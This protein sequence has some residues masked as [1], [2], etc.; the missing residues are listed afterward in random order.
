MKTNWLAP[1]AALALAVGSVAAA[2]RVPG[3]VDL[4]VRGEPRTPEG[5]TA[6]VKRGR[7]CGNEARGKVVSAALLSDE[8]L[9]EILPLERFG[10]VSYVVDSAG[11]TPVSGRF[12]KSI[13]RV[14]GAAEDVLLRRPDTV[15]VSDYTSGAAEAQL[16]AAG[17]CV[18]R[19]R[20][21]Q[22]FDDLFA[23][24]L[25]L[26]EATAS[27]A[28]ATALVERER[29]RLAELAS[30]PSQ[31]RRARVLLVQDPYSYGPGTLQADC[32]RLIGL[33]NVL[34]TNAFGKTP[35]LNVEQLLSLVPDFV[36]FASDTD[37]PRPLRPERRP[38]G[39]GWSRMR[40]LAEGRAFEVPSP[41]MA[42]I[43]HH[44]VDACE[45]YAR[46]VRG[47]S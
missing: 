5:G 8:L 30:P 4:V 39:A 37:A 15:V 28:A 13:P 10:G 18:L 1:L 33:D 22:T 31:E 47:A 6:H 44:A 35:F 41:W 17:V 34:A 21:P 46:L 36:F 45:A 7:A 16:G 38:A 42:S 2:S 32:L 43:S 23:E 11:S 3:D 12:P 19:L 26:G 25:E 9:L 29:A 20:A 24:A 27:R 40:A 14:S